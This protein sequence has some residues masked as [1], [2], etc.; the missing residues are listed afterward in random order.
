ML[1]CFRHEILFLPFLQVIK[2]GLR[3]Q[4][5]SER[6]LSSEG[7][8]E[9][10]SPLPTLAKLGFRRWVAAATAGTDYSELASFRVV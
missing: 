1:G 6:L 4:I 8:T 2:R 9:P 5:V 7:S 10:A 3:Y